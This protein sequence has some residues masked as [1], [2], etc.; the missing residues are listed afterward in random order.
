[1]E[2]VVFQRLTPR[3]GESM[4][5]DYDRIKTIATSFPNTTLRIDAN[6]AWS[7]KESVILLGRLENQGIISELIEQPVP[8]NDF[9]G[10]KYIKERTLTPLLADESVFSAKQAIALLEM[11]ACDLINI[12]LAKCGGISHALKI[13]DI[14]ELYHVKCMIG[15]MLEGAIS[16]GAAVHVASARSN[17]ITMLDLDGASL[18][19]TNPVIGGVHF[20][21]S[22]ITL[23]QSHGLGIEK[24]S[25]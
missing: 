11:D 8:A 24:I 17:V 15:C 5:K 2:L 3:V 16:V 10:M 25:I 12:K 14:A 9:R 21:E 19:R 20:N 4:N 22:D 23:T 7:A 6:Q 18:L 1:M 13:A